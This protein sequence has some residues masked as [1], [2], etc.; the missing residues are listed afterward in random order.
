MN[1]SIFTLRRKTVRFI[2]KVFHINNLSLWI[3]RKR[4]QLEKLFYRKTYTATDIISA[5]A[6]MGL[7][8]GTAIV[9]HCA[10]NNFYNYRGTAT[11]LIEALLKYLGPEGTLC[12]PAYPFDKD[13]ADKVFDVRS[14]KTAAGYLAETFRNYPGVKRSLNKLHSV[15]AIGKYADYLTNEHHLSETCFDEKSPYYKLAVLG[16]KSVSLGLPI[17]FVGTISHVCESL[18]RARLPYFRD[19]FTRKLSFQYIDQN[20]NRLQHSMY[21]GDSRKPYIRAKN[22]HLVDT[23]FDH[24]MFKHQRLSN[25]W[26]NMYDA[27]Y[28]VH[29]LSELAL[30]G[31]T[32]FTYPVFYK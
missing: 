5:L 14:D 16:G 13:N 27:R 22:T 7:R 9:V 11:D 28:T 17:Y 19:K 3:R 2:K 15:C 32:L 30:E 21:T 25:I 26:I 31:K 12:M 4:Q 20:G 1:T 29:R 6:D 24:G 8:P 10:M 18:L 23:Y